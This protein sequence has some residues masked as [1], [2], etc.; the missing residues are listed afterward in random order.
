[1]KNN[2]QDILFEY[3]RDLL[4]DTNRAKLDR[5][6]LS[7]ECDK[8]ADGLEY[9]GEVIKDE[10]RVLDQMALGNMDEEFQ[11]SHNYLA[12]PVKTVQSNLK[13]LSWVAKRVAAGD[14][15]QH[16]SS[17]GSFSTSFNEMIKQLS[18]YRDNMERISNTDA[19][20]GIKN[21]RAFN[22]E[23]E[24]LWQQKLI[25][26]I[27]FI[28]LDGLKYCNDTY[29]HLYGDQYIKSVCEILQ[30]NLKDKE[31]LYRMGGD[32]FLILSQ[33]DVEASCQN[34]LKRIRKQF[35]EQMRDSVLYPCDFSFGCVDPSLCHSMSECLS[36]ADQKMYEYKMTKAH[37]RR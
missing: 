2:D 30:I 13:H 34:R 4:Y 31:E 9:L 14:Y 26:T 17:L 1:M 19:L 28:D 33:E 8:L 23:S 18:E 6:N 15:Q 36:L 21:R 22:Y 3:I 5:L 29:G 24:I 20:T 16:V 27:V 37:H 25:K 32:E 10:K 35:Q 12:A 11:I 7:G